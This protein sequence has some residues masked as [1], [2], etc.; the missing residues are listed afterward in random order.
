MDMTR[1][2]FLQLLGAAPVVIAMPATARI[3][4]PEAPAEIALAME[5]AVE[6]SQQGRVICG[7]LFTREMGDPELYRQVLLED[8]HD[9][10]SPI[11]PL[12]VLEREVDRWPHRGF[13]RFMW[14]GSG[15]PI[16]DGQQMKTLAI[17][18]NLAELVELS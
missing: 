6:A 14:R 7:W 4:V 1:R 5:P 11:A 10:F 18:R 3:W 15:E 8:A 16:T 12:M 13:R 9:Y 17:W 2:G